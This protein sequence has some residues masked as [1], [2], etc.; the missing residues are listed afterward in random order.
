[1][2]PCRAMK[3]RQGWDWST[4]LSPGSLRIAI[5]L[6]LSWTFSTIKLGP[7]QDFERMTTKSSDP[8]SG[9]SISSTYFLQAQL[10]EGV[11]IWYAWYGFCVPSFW[12]S[13]C[14]HSLLQSQYSQ[15]LASYSLSVFPTSN[16]HVILITTH[17]HMYQAIK[18]GNSSYGALI[19]LLET[20]EH[21]L[22]WL[23]VYIRLPLM[24]AMGKILVK[25][26]TELLSTIA[27]VTSQIKQ[28]WPSECVCAAHYGSLDSSQCSDIGEEDPEG[29][30]SWGCATETR[31][32]DSW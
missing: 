20:I 6:T 23:D 9:W 13:F 30:W 8:S 12:C 18:D 10:L 1:M 3:N 25:I 21:F 32:I 16:L 24:A 5:L 26:I 4:I 28:S 14:R 17:V 22:G 15:L 2:Q 19:N 29:E 27:L 11:L 7:L 31:S